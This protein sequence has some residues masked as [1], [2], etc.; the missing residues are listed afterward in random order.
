LGFHAKSGPPTGPPSVEPNDRAK[1]GAQNADLSPTAERCGLRGEGLQS[2]LG[3]DGRDEVIDPNS[4]CEATDAYTG[5]ADLRV[6]SGANIHAAPRICIRWAGVPN[7]LITLGSADCADLVVVPTS[8]AN[9][10]NSK[11]S[12]VGQVGT[13]TTVGADRQLVEHQVAGRIEIGA[14]DDAAAIVDSESP[15]CTGNRTR[16]DPSPPPPSALRPPEPDSRVS[17]RAS[18]AGARDC[19]DLLASDSDTP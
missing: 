2:A 8:L 9:G 18:S 15:V 5:D 4:A 17:R 16:C 14:L 7:I 12:S 19:A 10:R 1:P 3:R 11:R 13:I 6:L